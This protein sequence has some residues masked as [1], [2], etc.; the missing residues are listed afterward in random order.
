MQR[1]LHWITLLALAFGAVFVAGFTPNAVSAQAITNGALTGEA[2]EYVVLYAEGASVATARAAVRAAG[3]TIVRENVQVGVATVH[4]AADF[5]V[6]ARRQGAL[7]GVARNAPVGRSPGDKP[8]KR[9]PAE[10]DGAHGPPKPGTPPRGGPKAQEEPLADLQ[11]DMQM[12]NATKDGSYAVQK[13]DQRVLVGVIDTGIDGNH[14]DIAPNFDRQLSRNFTTDIV[15]IDGPCEFASCVDPNNWDDG[16]HGT[17]VASTIASPLNG[18]G[19]A[20]VAPN[21]TLVNLRAGQD[22]GFFFLQPTIDALTY[23]GDNGIDVVNMSFYIDPWLF[24]CA[25]NPADSPDQQAE[26]RAI[27]TATNRALDY[28][29]AR[30]VTLIAAM[31]NDHSNLDAPLPDD[32]S[33]DYPVGTAHPR[34]I[35]RATCLSMP[36]EGNN[37]MSITAIGPSKAK[38]D[39]S[40]YG[41]GQATVAAPG[42]YFRDNFGTDRFRLA[43]NE[44]LAAYPKNVGIA[45]GAIDPTT[46]NVN[47]DYV[48]LVLRDCPARGACAYYQYI[49]GTSMAAPHATGV[50]ALIVSQYGVKDK[51]HKGGVTMDP[52][53]VEA[54]LRGSALDTPCPNPPTVDYTIVGRTPDFNATC[55]G[56][57]AFN[58]FYGDGIIDALKAVRFNRGR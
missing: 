6:A 58:N 35:D 36:H 45:E 37:V 2:N 8:G 9:D 11:W 18:L 10:R 19:I 15:D 38:A 34:P 31:G 14:P 5:M 50:A 52:A 29:H 53:Q 22:S 12:I 56:T 40:N 23:A 27:I 33:P 42:G 46:G 55:V 4:A 57:A 25:N 13:G 47:A 28:A 17:H 43:S 3:G 54:I 44:I 30:G 7:A 41:S 20:G 51:Q 21:V 48:D 39:Y 24:N 32:S 49:Q 1:T 16:G 26:Q